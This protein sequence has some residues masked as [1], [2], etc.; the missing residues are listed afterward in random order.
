MARPLTSRYWSVA[1][2]ADIW[3]DKWT[4]EV[5]IAGEVAGVAPEGE[6]ISYSI[7]IVRTR[8]N[9]PGD[10]LLGASTPLPHI[11]ARF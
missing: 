3:L 4:K 2:V 8:P 1:D 9:T 10:G 7:C 5:W 11:I 6:V